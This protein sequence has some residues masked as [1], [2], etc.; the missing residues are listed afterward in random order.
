MTRHSHKQR[1]AQ[2]TIILMFV[3]ALLP[4]L[5]ALL[6]YCNPQWIGRYKNYGTLIVPPVQLADGEL[7][8]LGAFSKQHF[9]EL[10]GRWLFIHVVPRL[11]STCD[12]ACLK[13]VY[14]SHQLWLMLNQNLMR[15]RRLV[16]FADA[17][18]GGK[19]MSAI[20]DPYLLYAVAGKTLFQALSESIPAPLISGT[21]V[22][23]DPLGNVMLW[24]NRDFDSYKV[25]KDLSRLF[26]TS[27]VG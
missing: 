5:L 14:N 8:P 2:R 21:V 11:S 17:E 26:R 25:K 18:A 22:L 9:S 13:S 15:I 10:D 1:N 20:N 6:F 27:R 19:V 24:Y 3:L 23:R 16:V 7:T 4:I 12:E